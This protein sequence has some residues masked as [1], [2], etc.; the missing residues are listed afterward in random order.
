MIHLIFLNTEET[1]DIQNNFLSE[2][3]AIVVFF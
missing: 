3:I 1:L 2:L